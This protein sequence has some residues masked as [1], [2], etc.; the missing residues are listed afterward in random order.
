M[1]AGSLCRGCCA[2]FDRHA[3]AV[4]YVSIP[5]GLEGGSLVNTGVLCNRALL[6]QTVLMQLCHVCKKPAQY[7]SFHRFILASVL[8][9]S[10]LTSNKSS[11][12][13]NQSR[14]TTQSGVIAGR[15]VAVEPRD[16]V[17]WL[18]GDMHLP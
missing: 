8:E 3:S 4:H 6:S 17:I 15:H 7:T 12:I 5:D 18:H 14:P 1:W 9:A 11:T 16:V 10:A 13:A 2:P